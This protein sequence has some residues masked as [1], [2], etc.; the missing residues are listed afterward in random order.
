[1]RRAGDEGSPTVRRSSALSN[2]TYRVIQWATG[3]V[4]RA[5]IEGI[6]DHPDLELVGCWVHSAAKSGKDVGELVDRGPVGVMA[7][8]DVDEVLAIDADCVV[9]APL[10]ADPDVVA[11]IL[12]SGKSVS[13]PVGWVYPDRSKTADLEAA[14]AAGNATLH[15]TGIHP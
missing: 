1:P 2:R 6:L 4:G 3:G 7:S 9:Y 8:N 14:C 15:G 5:A 13:T 12:R 11:R 10:L